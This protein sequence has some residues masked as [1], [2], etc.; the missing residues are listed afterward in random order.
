MLYDRVSLEELIVTGQAIFGFHKTWRLSITL[1]KPTTGLYWTSW[2]QLTPSYPFPW[3]SISL[4]SLSQIIKVNKSHRKIWFSAQEMNVCKKKYGWNTIIVAIHND[5]YILYT[6]YKLLLTSPTI[7]LL[8][9]I[10]L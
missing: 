4:L 2:I 9:Y 8:K 1:Q 3:G 7:W 10:R 5:N 6:Q